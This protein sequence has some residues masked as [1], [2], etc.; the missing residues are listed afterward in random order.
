[1][2]ITEVQAKRSGGWVSLLRSASAVVGLVLSVGFFLPPFIEWARRYEFVQAIQFAVFAFWTPVLLA[3]GAPWARLGLASNE[4]YEVTAKGE[5]ISPLT[6]RPFDRWQLKRSRI[7]GQS[8][9]I[10]VGCVFG[11]LAIFWR[12][13]PVV[14][15]LVR[16]PWLMV[17]EAI[18]LVTVGSLLFIDLVESPPIRP[19]APRTHRIA[20]SAILMWAVWVVAYLDGMSHVSWYH[21]FHH[22][23]GRGISQ[24]ADQ[25]LSAGSIWFMTAATFLPIIFW[26]L[27]HW[28]QSEED[29]SEELY[30]LVHEDRVRGFF[31]TRETK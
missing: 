6:L 20:I 27:M 12:V 14:D 22:V 9:A 13:A 29:P 16:Y 4:T 23:A 24:A 8:R 18:S 26:N 31:G 28:L 5:R 2:N 21:A 3:V 25:Q 10:F 1:M 15:G 19:G 30:R 11:L 7:S 17:V